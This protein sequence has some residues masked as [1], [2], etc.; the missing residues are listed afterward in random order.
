MLDRLG[1]MCQSAGRQ[2]AEP[3]KIALRQRGEEVSQIRWRRHGGRANGTRGCCRWVVLWCCD[4]E[5][6]GEL[7]RLHSERNVKFALEHDDDDVLGMGREANMCCRE[8]RLILYCGRRRSG[9][10]QW[11]F[12]SIP[13]CMQ[14]GRN[15]AMALVTCICVRT[16]AARGGGARGGVTDV[17][18]G[19][20]E[21]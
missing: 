19:Y 10:N 15:N 3:R 6:T 1:G 4:A 5:S 21:R 13:R 12:G 8:L 18:G 17:G 9:S 11:M 16:N 2:V 14:E 20:G 7:G